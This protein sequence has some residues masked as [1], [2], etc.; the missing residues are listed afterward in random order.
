M[1]AVVQRVNCASVE[2]DDKL[3]GEIKSGYLILL[4]VHGGDT[5]HDAEKLAE[6]IVKLRVMA[7]HNDKMNLSILDTKGEILVV[8]QFTLSANIKK[9]NRPSFVA[10]AKPDKARDLYRYFCKKL[11]ELGVIVKTGIFG[12]YMKIESELDGPVTILLESKDL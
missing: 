2:V 8:S 6:K 9:G 3:V 4:G 1:K 7:D 11:I 10:A 12:A 5:R